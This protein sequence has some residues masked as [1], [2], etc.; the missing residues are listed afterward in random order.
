MFPA[1]PNRRVLPWGLTGLGVA[2]VGS[3]LLLRDTTLLTVGALGLGGVA[4]G[5][6]LSRLVLGAEPEEPGDENDNA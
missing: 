3:G 4:A 2:G 1:F 5:Y 6:A